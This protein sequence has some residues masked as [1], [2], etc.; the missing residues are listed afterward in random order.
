[1]GVFFT[2]CSNIKNSVTKFVLCSV[3]SV[4]LAKTLLPAWDGYSSRVIIS[5]SILKLVLP[6]NVDPGTMGP[7][8]HGVFVEDG[9]EW[10]LD[11]GGH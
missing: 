11:L 1:M 10:N 5:V 6:A 7:F 2:S 9:A 8:Q 4:V 3:K